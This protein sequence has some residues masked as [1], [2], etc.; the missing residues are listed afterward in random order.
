VKQPGT[1]VFF[2]PENFNLDALLSLGEKMIKMIYASAV[3][4]FCSIL[5]SALVLG[6]LYWIVN[7][8]KLNYG[9]DAYWVFSVAFF[10]FLISWIVVFGLFVGQNSR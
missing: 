2:A 4:T 8:F 9:R 7:I 5:T 6:F 3:A 10:A 1:F